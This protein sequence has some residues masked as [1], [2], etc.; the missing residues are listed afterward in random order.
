MNKS[1][2]HSF[3]FN[4]TVPSAQQLILDTKEVANTLDIDMIILRITNKTKYN[5]KFCFYHSRDEACMNW[6]W[7]QL[8]VGYSIDEIIKEYFDTKLDQFYL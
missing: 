3:S 8:Q 7:V 2:S 4:A 5:T 6:A 1:P